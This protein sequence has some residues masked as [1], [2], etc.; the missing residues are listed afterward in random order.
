MVETRR[1]N[2]LG[3]GM[4]SRARWPAAPYRVALS[5]GADSAALAALALLTGNDVESFHIHHGLTDSDLMAEAAGNIASTLGIPM[6]VVGIEVEDGP[7]PEAQARDARYAA[8]AEL[9]PGSDSVLVGH[10]RDD[11]AETVLLNLIRGSGLRGL[12]G[13]PYH[14]EPNIFRPL[15]DVT[16]A[17]TRE[18]A[19]LAGLRF[20][21]DPTN[22]DR[23]LR[24]NWV[25]MD[26]IPT[27]QQVNPSIVD[28]L[29]RTAGN[30]LADADLLDESVPGRELI[31]AT[32]AKIPIGELVAA[33]QPV[34]W[35]M[36]NLRL[37]GLR[38]A[39]GLSSVEAD[40]VGDVIDGR[41]VATDLEGGVRVERDGPFLVFRREK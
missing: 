35:R 12:S 13:I 38:P 7:S 33:S 14:R 41:S 20:H 23:S 15:L 40:R 21:D 17:E 6:K 26:L 1:L 27:L 8:I 11:Q 37:E 9:G 4:S 16:R 24:R 32:D 19:T 31:D 25:R 18:Y 10:T 3:V 30:L 39:P 36:L 2:E 28:T 5:G 34:R 29:T 22:F